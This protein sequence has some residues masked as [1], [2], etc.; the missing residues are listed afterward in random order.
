MLQPKFRQFSLFHVRNFLYLCF[1]A[2]INGVKLAGLHWKKSD[3][4]YNVCP[5]K[6]QDLASCAVVA[7]V[8]QT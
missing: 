8:N 3:T 4:I 6:N 7:G 2:V 5:C 1:C